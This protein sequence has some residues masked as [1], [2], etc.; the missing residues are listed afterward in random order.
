MVRRAI[1]A[2]AVIL[3]VVLLYLLLF[4][5]F[6]QLLQIALRN[7]PTHFKD[8]S[9]YKDDFATVS[10][11]LRSYYTENAFPGRVRFRFS[12]SK[13]ILWFTDSALSERKVIP[14]DFL[15]QHVSDVQSKKLVEGWIE[16]NMIIFWEDETKY[17]GLLYSERPITSLISVGKW[18]ESMSINKLDRY[19]YE[20]GVLDGR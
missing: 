16:E 12:D 18:F 15:D 11:F 8:F 9:E 10:T 2:V 13:L 4:G 7:P 17:Y 1:K 6:G 20:I 14:V 19:W 5:N 3:I